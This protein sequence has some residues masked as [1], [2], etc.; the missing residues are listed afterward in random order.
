MASFTSLRLV[1]GRGRVLP[2]AGLLTL[3]R[4]LLRDVPGDL[5]LARLLRCHGLGALLGDKQVPVALHETA[6]ELSCRVLEGR[7]A[8]LGQLAGL[9]DRA[10]H[11]SVLPLQVVEELRLE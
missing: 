4:G 2:G 11:A 9:P 8:L 6:P 5:L 10:E 1:A 7:Q 3:G